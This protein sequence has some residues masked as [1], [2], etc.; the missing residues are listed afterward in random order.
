VKRTASTVSIILAL[1]LATASGA[2]AD[3]WPSTN[4]A[5]QAAGDPH[6]TLVGA[7]ADS[8]TI[9]LFSAESYLVYF[10]IRVDGGADAVTYG[11]HPTVDADGEYDPNGTNPDRDVVYGGCNLYASG[12]AFGEYCSD[13]T[14]VFVGD[15]VQLTIAAT[16]TV[17]VRQ[18]LGDES[19]HRFDWVTFTVAPAEGHTAQ[20]CK[21]GGWRDLGFRNQGLC[22]RDVKASE[23]APRG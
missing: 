5:N 16:S 19:S 3:P 11:L 14:P 13:A 9:E 2:A 10:E 17:E 15:S 21:Q 4:D 6:V 23:N 8:V 1:L 22:I 12:F 18:A 7:D 20:D